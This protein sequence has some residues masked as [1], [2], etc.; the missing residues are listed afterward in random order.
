MSLP[1]ARAGRNPKRPR[2]RGPIASDGD[3]TGLTATEFMA[4]ARALLVNGLHPV[5]IGK[6]DPDRPDKPAG[7]APWHSGVTGYDGT[8]PHADRVKDW[9][10]RRGAH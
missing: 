9:R 7:K 8:D 3:G 1:E 10:Q 5:A 6:L 2:A 4:G